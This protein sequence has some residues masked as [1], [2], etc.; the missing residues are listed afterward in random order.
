MQVFLVAVFFVWLIAWLDAFG[1]SF[2]ARLFQQPNSRLL[3]L[4]LDM[5]AIAVP[6]LSGYWVVTRTL[7]RKVSVIRAFVVNLLISGLP[8]FLSWAVYEIWLAIA[9][10]EGRLAFEADTAMGI[11]ITFLFCLLVFLIENLAVVC[12]LVILTLFRKNRR[13]E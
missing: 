6:P 5:L 3:S 4:S 13:K 7:D 11:G 1:F 9:R 2:S 12:F 10:N 8:I